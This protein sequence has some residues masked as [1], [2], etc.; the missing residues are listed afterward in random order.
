MLNHILL[1]GFL[2]NQIT[3]NLQKICV[4]R[5]KVLERSWIKVAK[6]LQ[7]LDVWDS[8]VPPIPYLLLTCTLSPP[9][10]QYYLFVFDHFNRDEYFD[11]EFLVTFTTGNQYCIALSAR[12][13]SSH[14]SYVPSA[15]EKAMMNYDL[16]EAEVAPAARFIR[17]CLHLNPE[18][19]LPARA[20]AAHP[21]LEN[22]FTCC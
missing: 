6:K 3:E 15:L 7:T 10:Y 2:L 13:P 16:P 19:R 1:V 4:L 9:P 11:G 12:K 20:L 14:Q 18:E 5:V 21:W 8:P 17:P 22:A